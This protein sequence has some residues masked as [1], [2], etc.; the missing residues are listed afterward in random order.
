MHIPFY[1]TERQHQAIGPA[2]QAAMET[3]LASN[4]YVLGE[5]VAA[6]EA[7]FAA[8]CQ[9]EHCVGVS[10]GLDALH[11]ALRALG[12]GSGDEVIVPAHC[13]IACVL[14][15]MHTGAKPV[16]VEPDPA[17]YNLDPSRIAAAVTTR[18]KAVMAVHLYG[19]PCP[20]AEI[21]Q[22]ARRHNLYVIED[23]AQA[24]GAIADGRPSG[25]WGHLA[26]TSFYPTKNLG[27]LG[28]GGA[29]TTNDAELARRMRVLRNYGSA[30][31]YHCETPGFNARLDE[32]QAALLRAKLPH[33]AD[34]NRQRR[35]L[36][37][38]YLSTLA[39]VP[40]LTL[41]PESPDSVW[42]LFVVRT[43]RRDGLQ[44]HLQQHGI[45][46]LIHY[47]V[48]PHLQAACAS[49]GHR[50]GDFPIAEKIAETCLSLPLYPGLTAEEANYIADTVRQFNFE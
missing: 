45:G 38:F 48:P 49:L 27:A 26:A 23:T 29:V 41:P 43:A 34:W 22:T 32:L 46:T 5:Q 18:T 3:V 12:I 16:L 33:L 1:S 47:P 24:H 7:E 39:N 4:R 25:S 8:L 42:H 50:P 13:F 19:R 30:E 37:A 31:K 11:L 36:A 21:V 9:T 40:D 2:L 20:V 35:Q 14:A 17:T 10:N 28:D 44:K 15:V 6:F